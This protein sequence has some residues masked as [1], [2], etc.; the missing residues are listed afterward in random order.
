MVKVFEQGDII[1]LDFD[2]QAGHEQRGHRPALV[3]SNNVYNHFHNLLMVCPITNTDRAFPSH[4]K[5]DNRTT[6]TGVSMC[7][8]VRAL[9]VYSRHGA[10]AEKAPEDLV[11]EV[12]DQIISF[13][14][15]L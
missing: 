5:L 8:Q 11:A 14:E 10:F 1:Y 15:I 6:T 7:D 2:P 12:V 9:D 13:V 4:V 3:V